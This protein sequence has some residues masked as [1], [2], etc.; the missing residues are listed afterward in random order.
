MRKTA[1]FE[2][3]KQVLEIERFIKDYFVNNQ[4]IQKNNVN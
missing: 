3:A 4:G 1:E 2:P